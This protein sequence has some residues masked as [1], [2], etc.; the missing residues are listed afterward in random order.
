M[1]FKSQILKIALFATGLS[2][3]VAEYI[4]STLASY[5]LGDSVVQFTLIVS[6]MMFAMGFGSHLSKYF[7]QNLIQKFIAIEFTLSLLVAFSSLVAY[8]AAAYTQY[9][10]FIIYF[11]AICIG[12][13]V[14]MEI[15]LVIRLNDEF[16]SLRVNVSS[17]MKLDYYGS[18]VGGLLYAFVALPYIGLTYTP[19][20]LSSVNFLV[21]LLLYRLVRKGIEKKITWRLD[22][23][24]LGLLAVIVF[25]VVG[26]ER[27]I[28]YGE[29]SRYKD[30]IVWVQQSKYQRIVITEWK[31]NFWLFI[32]GNQQLCSYD[33]AMYHEPLV[34]PAMGLIKDPSRVLIMGGGDGCAVRELLKYPQL[35]SIDLVDLDPAMTDLGKN[36]P[37]LRG[38]NQDAFWNPKLT[39]FN[40]DGYK[41]LENS[42]QY[43]DMI[44]VDLPDPKS[45]EL[46]RLYSFEFYKLCA[47]RLRPHGVIV[48]QAGSP[49]YATKAFVCI[50]KTMQA[51]GFNT[52]M[53]HN[54]VIT[55]GEWGW[56]LGSKDIPQPQL[57]AQLQSLRFEGLDSRWLNTEAMGL[58]T[59][60]G[61]DIYVNAHTD[62]IRVNT[63]HDPVLY[64]YYLK[65]NWDLY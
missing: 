46:G 15:P 58:I 44:V 39:V 49:Y 64:R 22:V 1:N 13:L 42:M 14:G 4:L 9:V 61:K 24:A 59:S 23:A 18:L 2:G 19:F 41:F 60:F 50:D 48:T 51:A 36:N 37:L 10:G 21:A 35:D 55:L 40:V 45:V 56:V 25:G 26:S 16:E 31:E 20:I 27:V 57:R 63:V 17:V 34:H 54:Q 32:N 28:L 33:E 5:F 11:F 47:R 62:S 12:L 29:Q 8:T 52:Q 6:V 65:G 38:L 30:K 43:Y 3:I 7:Q 53:L